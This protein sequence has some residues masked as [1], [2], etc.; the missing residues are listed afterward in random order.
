[1]IEKKRTD[2]FFALGSPA[3]IW[4]ILFFYLPIV[5]L[6]C[7]GFFLIDTELGFQ[8]LTFRNF[9][10]FLSVTTLSVLFKTL[11]IAIST[12]IISALIA[13]PLA[14]FI[15]FTAKRYRY[16]LLFFVIVPFWTNFL[17]HVYAWFFILEPGGIINS[18]LLWLGI[19]REPIH[20]FNSLFSVMLMMVY[21]Y[22]PFMVL[23]LYSSLER[24]QKEFIEASYDLGAGFLQTFIHVVFPM[25]LP[26]LKAGFFLV[27]IPSFGE[28][29]IPELMGGDKYFFVGNV[30]TQLILGEQTGQLGAAFALIS[31][32]FLLLALFFLLKGFEFISKRLDKRSA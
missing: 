1:M 31:I 27:L 29:I 16:V 4:Q 26:S 28:F 6:F 12:A 3:F 21:M 7:T 22:L 32:V 24:F 20:L 30:I 19:I 9:A 15:A 11:I 13:Y 17:L 10:P 23:P 8:G 5:L 25:T 18:A 2:W 14:F